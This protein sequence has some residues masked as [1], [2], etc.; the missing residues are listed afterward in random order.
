MAR[1]TFKTVNAA[2]AAAGAKEVLFQGNGYLYFAE[3]DAD[4]WPEVSVAVPRLN[5]LSLEAWIES[6]RRLKAQYDDGK[7]F[8]RPTR[9]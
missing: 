9:L 4:C 3:G 2:L 8:S 5:H 7:S 1:L 6:W